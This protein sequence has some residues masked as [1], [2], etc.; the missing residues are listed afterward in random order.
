MP[1]S[2]VTSISASAAASGRFGVTTSASGRSSLASAA[3]AS[4][5]SSTSPDL[6]IITGSRTMRAFPCARRRSD[7]T[8]MIGAVE[9][10]PIFTA[11][12]PKSESTESS[13][14]PTNSGG[15]LKTPWTP[16]EFCAVTAVITLIPNTRNAEKVLRSAWMP[17]PPPES[18]PA[19]VRALG[20]LITTRSIPLPDHRNDQRELAAGLVGGQSHQVGGRGGAHD[21]LELL[22]QLPR[23]H[24]LHLAED[25]ADRAQ[26][27]EDAVRRLV[28]HARR[29][30]LP[31]R[32]EPIDPTAALDRQ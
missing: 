32:L 15:R 12:A 21:L 7:T 16:T 14:R 25:L 6:A 8:P 5:W 22:G 11:S 18:E 31:Q 2:V 29:L 1:A 28:H 4:G 20:T 17:A 13:W 30:E 27:R 10:I 19:M 3:R 9:S 26:G 24:Q 23:H